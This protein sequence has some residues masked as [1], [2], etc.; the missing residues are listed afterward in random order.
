MKKL[1]LD[2]DDVLVKYQS[3]LD[4]VDEAIKAQYRAKTPGEKDRQDEIPGLF[5]LMEP[6]PGAIPAVRKLNEVYDIYILSTAPWGNP[7]AWTEKVLWLKNRFGDL[8]KKKVILT[9]RKDLIR[10]DI[11]IDDKDKNGACDFQGEWIRFG[12]ERYPDWKTV[13]EYLLNKK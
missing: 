4:K 1:F 7:L 2:M 5:S 13:L 9:H 8:F 11:L 6:M 10:G 12:S 3:G